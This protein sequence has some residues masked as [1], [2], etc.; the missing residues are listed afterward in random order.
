MN[1]S[2]Q[3]DELTSLLQKEKEADF[4]QYKKYV[5]SLSLAERKKQGFTWHPVGVKKSGYTFGER[6]FVIVERSDEEKRNHQFRAGKIVNLY[7][8]DANAYE[9]EKAA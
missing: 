1:E 4:E 5:Q 3:I 8:L 2:I 9:R 6:A 7:T